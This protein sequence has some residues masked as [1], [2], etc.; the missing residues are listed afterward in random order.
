MYIAEPERND[1]KINYI[2]QDI[3]YLKKHI[4][5]LLTFLLLQIAIL[6]FIEEYTRQFR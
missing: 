3:N 6:F 5:I 2:N 4:I 1:F